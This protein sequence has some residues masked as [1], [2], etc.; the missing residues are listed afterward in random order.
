MSFQPS[1]RDVL[2]A[3]AVAGLGAGIGGD[4]LLSALTA[5]AACNISLEGIKHVVFLIQENRSFDNYFGSY[6][7][8]HGFGDG[9]PRFS[10][11]YVAPAT[12]TGYQDPLKPFHIDTA[13]GLP[14]LP[15]QGVCTNDVEHQ[16]AGQHDSWNGGACDNWMN[17]H[18]ATEPTEKQAALTMG[19]YTRADLPFY[20]ALADHFT[21]CDNYFSSVIAGTDINRLYTLTGT[22]DPDGWDGGCQFLNTKVGTIQNPGANLGTAG[23]WKPYPEHL[24]Q[25]GISWKCYGTAD[26]QLGDNALRYFPRFR[27]AG[28]DPSL[29]GPAFAS[30][31]L[32]DFAADCVAGTLPSVSWIFT[33]LTDTEH[34]PDPVTWGES[35]THTL[36][37]A[38]V[39]SGLW[40]SSALFLTYDENGGFFDH[41]VPPTAP[42]GTPG[43]YLN[44][45]AL[46]T[47]AKAE[48]RTVKGV[49]KS[50]DPIGLGFRV[51]MLVISPFSRNPTPSGG[52]LVCPDRFDHTSMLRFVETLTGVR[53]PDRDPVARVPGL[54]PW[55]RNMVGDLS[56]AFNFAAPADPSVP[57]S[58]VAM[59]PNRADPRVL[60]Q[61]VATG[62]AGTLGF[63]P[64]VQD[65]RVPAQN[66]TAVQEPLPAP[67]KRPS[68]PIG[69]RSLAAC[70]VPTPRLPAAGLPG[71]SGR[72]PVTGAPSPVPAMAEVIVGAALL[73]GAWWARRGA[74]GHADRAG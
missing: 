38:L 74:T 63:Q 3:G 8:I 73:T 58:L 64:I 6:K 69:G 70:I 28:G 65:P 11:S 48:A 26:G 44:R 46:S 67:P 33:G 32:V 59:V 25:A 51:P 2:K 22:C 14:P 19:Y 62:T 36:L 47:T 16:W 24:T 66:S 60:Q 12:P 49:D 61:C 30:E 50:G 21:I 5:S 72:P 7:G 57:T 52:P 17:S 23:R 20:Y 18:L 56:T 54:S 15:H 45:A 34:P 37:T 42:P 40:S 31:A 53:V 9:S 4:A 71:S 1:R 13:L 35:I 55:R 29:S 27:P 43:E 41:V 68:G 39:T 10:Q